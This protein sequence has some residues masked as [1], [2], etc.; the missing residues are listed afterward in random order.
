MEAN[1]IINE[2]LVLCLNSLKYLSY[3]KGKMW[4]HFRYKN[5]TQLIM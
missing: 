1:L 4:K 3:V 5:N 2:L